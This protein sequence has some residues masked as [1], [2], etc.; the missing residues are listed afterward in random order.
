MKTKH[1]IIAAILIILSTAGM[2]AVDYF[3]VKGLNQAKQD[4]VERTSLRHQREDE[5]LAVI[6]TE[7]MQ[8]RL[9]AFNDTGLQQSVT[10]LRAFENKAREWHAAVHQMSPINPNSGLAL[11]ISSFCH[12]HAGYLEKE[13]GKP[14]LDDGGASEKFSLGSANEGLALLQQAAPNYVSI[15][16]A[17]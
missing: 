9:G 14:R 6:W 1:V 2:C 3:R 7:F 4:E 17:H 8:L 15:L 10:D 11:K 16:L 12:I 13:I 5:A